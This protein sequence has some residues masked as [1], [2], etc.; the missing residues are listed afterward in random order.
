MPVPWLLLSTPGPWPAACLS[1]DTGWLAQAPAPPEGYV[2][3]LAALYSQNAGPRLSKKAFRSVPQAP[4]RILDA[5]DM[6]DD[7]Y[8]N[9]LDWGSNNVVSWPGLAECMRCV[10]RSQRAL[11]ACR[12]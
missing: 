9:L 6:L 3:G 10:Q 5:P 4:E 8:L 12:P 1:A 2:S 11:H 7:Y